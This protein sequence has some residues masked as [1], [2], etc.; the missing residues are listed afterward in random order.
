MA[1]VLPLCCH[2]FVYCNVRALS[3]RGELARCKRLSGSPTVDVNV[4]LVLL[5]Y[6]FWTV[7]VSDFLFLLISCS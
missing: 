3:V 7:G 2:M 6:L 4:C 5:L 1:Y